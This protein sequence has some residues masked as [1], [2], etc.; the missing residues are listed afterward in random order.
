MNYIEY[1]R[2]I[3]NKLGEIKAADRIEE[4]P[5][6]DVV[7][8]ELN[9]LSKQVA[10]E[11]QEETKVIWNKESYT[12]LLHESPPTR[13]LAL[14]SMLASWLGWIMNEKHGE[15]GLFSSEDCLKRIEEAY[16]FGVNLS[17]QNQCPY[18]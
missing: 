4:G 15:T 6:Y 1:M 2:I 9:K 7:I 8:R 11:L 14:E 18:F 3:E 12:L 13:L 17:K 16:S 5:W 10:M